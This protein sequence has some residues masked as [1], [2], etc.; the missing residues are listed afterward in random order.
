M[1]LSVSVKDLVP[2]TFTPMTEYGD[3]NIE[4][5]DV[6]QKFLKDRG[7][8]YVYEKRPEEANENNTCRR[9]DRSISTVAVFEGEEFSPKQSRSCQEK[10]KPE[11]GNT[12]EFLQRSVPVR[13]T[14]LLATKI[15]Y[16]NRAKIK[17]EAHLRKTYSCP[18]RKKPLEDIEG[19]VW[20]SAPEVKLNNKP[21]TLDEVN[22]IVQKGRGKF[23]PGPNGVL[24][25]LHKRCPNL[26][27]EQWMTVEGFYIIKE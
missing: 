5:I 21:P 25:L 7:I 4:A 15:R 1:S 19:L 27:S 20:P 2:A 22:S 10:T 11:E 13:Q 17:I 16:L 12:R 8:N 18:E 26:L 14:A 3:V 6:Y 23:S 9:K 24:Y